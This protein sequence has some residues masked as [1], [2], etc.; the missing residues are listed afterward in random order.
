MTRSEQL[1]LKGVTGGHRLSF[2]FRQTPEW[3]ARRTQQALS[4]AP[5]LS[6][7]T[8]TRARGNTD[9]PLNLHSS[10]KWHLCTF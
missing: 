5:R 9:T 4:T 1:P 3:D 6:N 8:G 7:G 2:G 10:G